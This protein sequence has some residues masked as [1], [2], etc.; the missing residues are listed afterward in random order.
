MALVFI[1]HSSIDNEKIKKIAEEIENNGF[2]NIFLDI[3]EEA[4]IKAGEEWEKRLYTEIKRSHAIII[5]LSPAWLESKW[6]FV[7]YTQ[8]R[9]LGKEIIPIII[10]HGEDGNVN[11]WIA[12]NIQKSDLTKDENVLK[13]VI[14]RIK[15]IALGTQK[16]FKWDRDRPPYPGLISFEKEDAAVFFGKDEDT[17]AG[18]EKLNAMK[19][20]NFPKL[21][22][23]VSA[24]GM[25]KSSLLKAGI[26]PKLEL[27][28]AKR[29]S[30]LPVLRPNKR[31][32]YE[33][34]KLLARYLKKEQQYKEIY[35]V[36]QGEEYKERL[37]DILTDIELSSS[38]EVSIL[39]PVDQAEEFYSIA[40]Q[41]EKERFFEVLNYL[42]EQKENFFTIWTLRADYLK[43][44]QTDKNTKT[45]Q[46]YEEIFSL[47]PVSK[48]QI[49]SIVKEPAYVAGI[50]I[51]DKLVE[52][53]KEDIKTTDA[54]PL[55]ALCLHELYL[56]H[57]GDGRLTLSDYQSLADDKETN[58]IEN[59][60]KIKA[61]EAIARYMQD[62]KKIKAL[63]EA[64]IPHLVRVNSKNEY[65][66]KPANLNTLPENAKDMIEVL[67][68]ARL[69]ILKADNNETTIEI[70]HEALMRK[71]PL[72]L[73][74]LKEEHEFLIGKS[75]LEMA[76][77]EWEETEDKKKDKALLGGIRLDKALAWKGKLDDEKEIAYI[78]RSY[79]Y[80]K[81]QKKKR[82][83]FV[84]FAFVLVSLL[85][86]FS[87][88]KM[89]EAVKAK[90]GLA[91]S[92]IIA[93]EET[94]KAEKQTKISNDRLYDSL[95][96]E[97]MTQRDHVKDLLKAKLIFASAV[98]SPNRL[99]EENAKILYTNVLKESHLLNIFEYNVSMDEGAIFNQSGDRILSWGKNRVKLWRTDSNASEL[100]LDHG[101]SVR[102]AIFNQ[103]GDR[104]LSWG[105][106]KVKL[107][108]TDSNESGLVLD[109]DS[110]E[111]A[112]FNQNGDR[113]L[114]WGWGGVKLWRTDSNES[115]L[116][117]DHD[118]V[119]G[120][121]F[122]QNGDRILSWGWRVKLWRTDSN[123]PLLVFDHG[124]YFGHVRGAIFNQNEDRILSWGKN[125]VKLWRT[126]S[127]ESEM[128]LEH[129]S[130][131]GAIFNKNEDRILSWGGQRV[132]LWRTD[133]NT[134]ELIL[135]HKDVDSAIFN[136]NEDRILSW[137][138]KGVKLWRTDSNAPLLVLDHGDYVRDVTF[139]QSGDRILSWGGHRVKLWRTDSNAPLLILDHGD[140]V[141]YVT[142]NQSG[143]RILSWGRHR[144]K[145]W[146]TDSN[147]SELILEHNSVDG[148]IF[149][150]NEDRI[151]SWGRNGVKLWP[152][153][154]NRKL[155]KN[156]YSLE[157][158]VE[159]GVYLSPAGEVKSL[160]KK[161]WLKKKEEYKSKVKY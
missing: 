22:N 49:A 94:K 47:T 112:I 139:N 98:K 57:G 156:F 121:I 95:I 4:G 15:E 67:V 131:N 155:D 157:A 125:R 74:W 1:S 10:D 76:L 150:Q 60:I 29:W 97:G 154:R 41:K 81:K 11:K 136:K 54:L 129:N 106:N 25:G 78:E 151:L 45:I 38:Q 3:D 90:A 127:N 70:S 122:N 96:K 2:E 19:N 8:A 145:L 65:V 30:I 62:K 53:I 93:N 46:K 113:I 50:D 120:A 28:Y 118:F 148:A 71:W 42:V 138:M 59:I 23:I 130:V 99:Q 117:L 108:R 92:L 105:E 88:S 116:V 44:F 152:L 101:D 39:L 134:S 82:K 52:K 14:A 43:E 159:N 158:E 142:F 63:K 34:A 107:W 91:K 6:C 51:D 140:D 102:G 143:D 103:S 80:D 56:K 18:I 48:E 26:L 31:P 86:I 104:I 77:S 161:E 153:Y 12:D 27:S 115:E 40:D 7:E 69:L 68:K 160:S 32:L 149:N 110:V 72:L 33:F 17:V 73:S 64:F 147:E 135:D 119:D 5:A 89:N 35:M 144:V 36:L 146:R 137:G 9:A 20:K 21:L 84:G 111:G 123:T 61:D 13:R 128:I 133:S 85:A 109:H 124:D 126:D 75:Q 37:D 83:M 141:R 100:V 16:G 79:A 132:K 66:K 87:F 24:S 55:L 114:S 58:P